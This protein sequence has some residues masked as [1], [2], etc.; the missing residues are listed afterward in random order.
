MY[1]KTSELSILTEFLNFEN[2][3]S[4]HGARIKI[5][6]GARTSPRPVFWLKYAGSGNFFD[7]MCTG[8]EVA[9]YHDIELKLSILWIWT[10]S[11]SKQLY[12]ILRRM[13]LL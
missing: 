7:T 5:R 12:K 1:K 4:I 11:N 6:D 2:S 13:S 10:V 8:L 9:S 3:F